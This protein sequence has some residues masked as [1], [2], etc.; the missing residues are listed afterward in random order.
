MW[1]KDFDELPVASYIKMLNELSEAYPNLK[2]I[3]ST[4]R[5]A[6]T[7][8]ENAWGAIALHSGG[9]AHVA[10]HNVD[11]SGSSWAA[12]TALPRG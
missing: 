7:A 8:S 3:A 2:V 12:A 9:I 10:Q 6:R 11:D 5:T 1:R 4:L